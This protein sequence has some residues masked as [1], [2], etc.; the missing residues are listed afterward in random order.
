MSS[1]DPVLHSHLAPH[2][3]GSSD[4]EI[5]SQEHTSDGEHLSSSNEY[6]DGPTSGDSGSELNGTD[7]DEDYEEHEDDEE[8]EEDSVPDPLYVADMLRQ[9]GVDW[10]HHPEYATHRIIVVKD[11]AVVTT[12]STQTNTESTQCYRVMTQFLSLASAVFR[13]A[14]MALDTG[15]WSGEPCRQGQ[16]Q[17]QGHDRLACIQTLSEREASTF[18][19]PKLPLERRPLPTGLTLPPLIQAYDDLNSD[20]NLL[21]V[22]KICLPHPEHFPALLQVMYDLDL[23]RW[24]RMSFTPSTIAAITHNVRRLECSTDITLRCLEYYQRI[25]LDMPEQHAATTSKD[26][27]DVDASMR[28]LEE[29]YRLAVESGLLSTV[30]E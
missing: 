28:E 19:F 9:L 12:C 26:D 2:H 15:A 7:S 14:F 10:I 20:H 8:C 30:E 29:L 17:G 13:D 22:L 16:G 11:P 1:K 4:D 24:E 25:R 3:S 5:S 6:Q 18:K 21:P 27:D 23:D